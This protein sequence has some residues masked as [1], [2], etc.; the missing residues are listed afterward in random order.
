LA[1]NGGELMRAGQ[2][3]S[4]SSIDPNLQRIIQQNKELTMAKFAPPNI[5][6][7]LADDQGFTDVN[8]LYLG[9][10]NNMRMK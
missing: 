3:T 2:S 10:Q 9:W 8:F 6:N 7:H 4:T 5:P 1:N